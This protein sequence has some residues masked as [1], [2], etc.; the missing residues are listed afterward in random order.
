MLLLEIAAQGVKGVSPSGGSARLRPG[1]NLVPFDGASLR[2]L[3]E[4]LFRPAPGDAEAL[5]GS[6]PGR[7]ALRAGATVLGDDGGTWRLVRDFAAGFQLQRLDPQRRA[8]ALVAQ[9]P[10]AVARALAERVGL[11]GPAEARLLTL[12]LSDL[13]SRRG[14]PAP[15]AVPAAAPAPRRA[16]DPAQA[17]RRLAELRAELARAERAEKLQYQLDGLQSRLFKAEEALREGARLRDAVAAAEAQVAGNAPAA[18]V[19]EKLGDVEAKL[20]AHGRATARRDE[21]LAK[22]EADRA[23]LADAEAVGA[24][25]PPWADPRWWAGVV[26]GLGAVAAG[27]A[28]R[29]SAELRYLAL[30][31]IPAFGWAAWVALGWV[32]ALEGRGRLGRRRQLVDEHEHKVQ[33]AFE[34]ESAEVREALAALGVSGLGELRD[35][36][37]RLADARGAAEAARARL[38]ELESSEATRSA[39]QERAAVESELRGVEHALTE[40]AGGFVRD[41]RSIEMEISRIEAEAAAPAAPAPA[42]AGAATPATAT[43]APEAADPFPEVLACAAAALGGSPEAAVEAIRPRGSQLLAALSGG[44]LGAFA[45]DRGGR[46]VAQAGTR[47]TPADQLPALDRDLL[48][49]SVKLAFLERALAGGRRVALVDDVFAPLPEAARRLAGRL[50][51]Q[52]ARPGQLLHATNDPACREAA[53]HVAQAA[54]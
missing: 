47:V 33:E 49:L 31:D 13:P 9:E 40:V 50:L 35:A 28:L 53:D 41:P 15:A 21:G 25:R 11:P 34:R 14:A 20:A 51:K 42:P 26:V 45:L 27:I 37:Q 5:C 39:E 24:P 1:Y 44:R 46:V 6:A 29:R 2:R 16:L 52:L 7:G 17:S 54:P 30:L 10:A 36:L 48:F 3:L 23:A 38:A 22:V 32:Q 43:A 4:A 19:A 12:A 8:F 18:A